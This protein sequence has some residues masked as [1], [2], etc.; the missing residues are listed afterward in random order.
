M[1]EN[2]RRG[3]DLAKVIGYFYLLLA[4]F[5]IIALFIIPE[6]TTLLLISIAFYFIMFL[7][8][9]FITTKYDNDSV[10]WIIIAVTG[11]LVFIWTLNILGAGLFILSLV[12]ANDIRKELV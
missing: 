3:K 1:F 7:V 8:L 11:F 4:I 5:F 10:T 9:Y 6:Y 12:A 2:R